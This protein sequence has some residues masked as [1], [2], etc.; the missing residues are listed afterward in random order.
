ME[1]R[2]GDYVYIS[3]DALT[4]S[5][6][7]WVEGTSWLTGMSGLLPESYTERT[8][9]SDAWTLH[10]KVAL[11]HLDPTEIR[12]V[13]RNQQNLASNQNSRSSTMEKKPKETE[14]TKKHDGKGDSNEHDATYEN[15]KDIKKTVEEIEKEQNEVSKFLNKLYLYLPCPP[16]IQVNLILAKSRDSVSLNKCFNCIN[17]TSYKPLA[18]FPSFSFLSIFFSTPFVFRDFEA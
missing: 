8:A 4:S 18:V 14:E 16:Q 9:E 17:C 5:P 10:R 12:Q 1:L 3:G 11:N 6:D 15:L 13:D 7:G 2:T